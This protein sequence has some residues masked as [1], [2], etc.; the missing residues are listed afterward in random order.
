MSPL[1]WFYLMLVFWLGWL[2]SSMSIFYWF[3]LTALMITPPPLFFFFFFYFNDQFY[4]FIDN[5]NNNVSLINLVFFYS[6]DF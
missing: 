2:I 4:L 1:W 3:K 5:V 6:Y